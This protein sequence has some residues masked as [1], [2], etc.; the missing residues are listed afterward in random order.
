M[1]MS[2]LLKKRNQAVELK[3]AVFQ[4][5]NLAFFKVEFFNMEI[6]ELLGVEMKI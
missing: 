6:K 4:G 3:L 2:N 5:L 1:T